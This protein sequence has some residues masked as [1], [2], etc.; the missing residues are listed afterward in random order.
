MLIVKIYQ[1]ALSSILKLAATNFISCL[2]LL[3][4]AILSD[5]SQ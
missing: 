1:R 4:D 2:L 3:T 5:H